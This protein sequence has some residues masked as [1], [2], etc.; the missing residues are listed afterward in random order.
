MSDR[1]TG[2]I[3]ENPKKNNM[4]NAK[5]T[6]MEHEES[7]AGPS[8]RI[9][10][11]ENL[12][13]LSLETKDGGEKQKNLINPTNSTSLSSPQ[14]TLM[15]TPSITTKEKE[16]EE[17][18]DTPMAY[19]SLSDETDVETVKKSKE[20]TDRKSASYKKMR[21][22]KISKVKRRIIK[23]TEEE[24]ESIENEGK[25]SVLLLMYNIMV[26]QQMMSRRKHMKQS[27]K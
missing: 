18:A 9:M 14:N 5:E 16:M 7:T 20:R 8:R 11:D 26:W 22:T 17:D 24:E 21:E 6:E 4:E 2:D 12:I 27:E 1:N 3:M 19:I 15:Q 10:E 25:D 23:D 13:E